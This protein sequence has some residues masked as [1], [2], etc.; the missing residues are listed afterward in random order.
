MD[1]VKTIKQYTEG[2]I[3]RDEMNTKLEII[4]VH[5]AVEGLDFTGFDYDNQAWIR[6]NLSR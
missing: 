2:L 6:V 3:T 1:L 5:G 4:G